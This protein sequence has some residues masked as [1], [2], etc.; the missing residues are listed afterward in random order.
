MYRSH[1]KNS[2]LQPDQAYGWAATY[3]Y[4]RFS[5]ATL[6]RQEMCE[7]MLNLGIIFAGLK[8]YATADTMFEE[9]KSCFTQQQRA[10][11]AL[12]QADTYLYRDR[13]QDAVNLLQEAITW[14]SENLDVRWALARAMLQNNDIGGAKAIYEGLLAEDGLDENAKARLQAE[15]DRVNSL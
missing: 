10:I 12:Y 2:P 14:D 7:S 3:C 15:F 5:T 6:P 11:A 4:Y 9:G 1:P 13:A 8:D